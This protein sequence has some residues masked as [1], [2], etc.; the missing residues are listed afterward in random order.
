MGVASSTAADSLPPSIIDDQSHAS[1]SDMMAVSLCSKTKT[2]VFVFSM[3]SQDSVT[4]ALMDMAYDPTAQ[5]MLSEN[6]VIDVHV[7]FPNKVPPTA[8]SAHN[9]LRAV[10]VCAEAMPKEADTRKIK[11][12][13]A[14]TKE[15][16]AIGVIKTAF[17]VYC[18]ARN[19]SGQV[20]TRVES[21]N[22]V[23][24]RVES[25]PGPK[26]P[27]PPGANDAPD[28]RRKVDEDPYEY[29]AVNFPEMET[30]KIDYDLPK[31]EDP[32]EMVRMC[33]TGTVGVADEGQAAALAAKPKFDWDPPDN[34]DKVWD[35]DEPGEIYV[36]RQDGLVRQIRSY[37]VLCSGMCGPGSG[38]LEKFEN[39]ANYELAHAKHAHIIEDAA[40]L[41]FRDKDYR[42][43]DGAAVLLYRDKDGKLK[44]PT[45]ERIIALKRMASQLAT[46]RLALRMRMD[47]HTKMFEDV[48]NAMPDKTENEKEEKEYEQRS[49]ENWKDQVYSK[50]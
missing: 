50:F 9:V 11:V 47:A 27:A 46:L 31:I 34:P 7:E 35:F 43:F 25:L 1:H 20:F 28:K 39:F 29:N 6:N 30:A 18:K 24:S 5:H 36:D 49:I 22:S 8:E 13:L 41:V 3:E 45:D 40:A 44:K 17:S 37:W 42:F 16:V 48:V 15:D 4:K 26:N 19:L 2:R 14:I 32:D 21:G 33:T 38:T 12:A 10:L 23:T